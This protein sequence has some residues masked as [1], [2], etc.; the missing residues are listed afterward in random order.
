MKKKEIKMPNPKNYTCKHCN[1]TFLPETKH[2]KTFE[3][4]KDCLK[5]AKESE[6]EE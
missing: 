6:E 4:C 5:E 3:I 1:A 2:Q